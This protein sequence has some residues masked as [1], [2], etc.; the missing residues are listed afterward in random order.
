MRVE[1]LPVNEVSRAIILLATTP[2]E[3]TVFHPYNIHMQLLGDVLSALS[4]V[5][6]GIRFVEQEEFR[7]AMDKAAA[8]PQNAKI[9]ASL[10]AYKDMA[11]GHITTEVSRDNE[12]TT[13]VLYRLGFAFSPTSWDYIERMLTAI[14]GLG[15]FD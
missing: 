12:Y 2:Q 15:F 8:D 9:M 3:C 4:T 11:H 14:N 1:F 10:L 7:Q 5:G 13:Q 6:N